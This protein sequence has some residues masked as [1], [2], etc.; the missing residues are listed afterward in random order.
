MASL[1]RREGN[2]YSSA[3]Q[4]L[5]EQDPAPYCLLAIVRPVSRPSGPLLLLKEIGEK[6]IL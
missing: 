2:T 6:S 5:L 3:C 4:D 1:K